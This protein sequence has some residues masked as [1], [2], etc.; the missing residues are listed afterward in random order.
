MPIYNPY[1]S[2]FENDHPSGLYMDKIQWSI[3]QHY[4]SY[5]SRSIMN[6]LR[7]GDLKITYAV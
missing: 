5:Y 2:I 4:V 6:E 3:P 1:V 7:A